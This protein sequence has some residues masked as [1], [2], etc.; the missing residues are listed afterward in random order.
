MNDP[1]SS[2]SPSSSNW[3]L[4]FAVTIIA[5]FAIVAGVVIYIFSALSRI[6]DAAVEQAQEILASVQDLAEAFRQG[7]V[8]TRF[9]AYAT[10]ISGST[11]LQVA[12]LDRVEVFTREDRASIFWGAVPLPDVV[13]SAT[14]PVQYTAYVDLDQPWHLDLEDHTLLVEAPA[15]EFNRPNIDAS[16]IEWTVMEDSILRNEEEALDALKKGLTSMSHSRTRELEDAVRETARARVE[17]FV[18]TWLL[19]SF[20]AAGQVRIEVIFADEAGP[21]APV[22]QNRPKD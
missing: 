17:G 20:P 22:L 2:S 8:E 7:T 19:Q 16:R 11:Y 21:I 12:T 18:R 14:A 13:V 10:E 5:V 15:I 1:Q 6:P 3:P 4:A 9:M